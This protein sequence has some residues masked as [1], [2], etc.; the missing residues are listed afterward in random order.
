MLGW[1]S[2]HAPPE[3]EFGDPGFMLFRRSGNPARQRK[4]SFGPD[5]RGSLRDN[6]LPLILSQISSVVARIFRGRQSAHGVVF[7]G[8]LFPSAGQGLKMPVLA[9]GAGDSLRCLPR[10]IFAVLPPAV[11]RV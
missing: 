11:P 4:S 6:G 7:D 2:A 1:C 8:R 3:D 10:V 9:A 5:R